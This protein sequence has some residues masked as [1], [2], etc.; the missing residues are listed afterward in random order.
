MTFQGSTFWWITGTQL[1]YGPAVIEEVTRHSQIMVDALNSDPAIVGRVVFH[2]AMTHAQDITDTLL[3]ANADPTCAGV[4]AWMHTFSPAKMWITGLS[5]LQ[6]PYL[7]FN[8]QFSRDIPWDSIDMD[9]MNLNQSAHGDRE[10]GFLT[11]R[12]RLPRKVIAGHWED[13]SVRRR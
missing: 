13:L 12:L 2:G 4:I 8:T 7:H 5:R 3:A 11:A 9:Y 6:K 1:L 10:H